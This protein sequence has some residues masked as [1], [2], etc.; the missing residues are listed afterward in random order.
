MHRFWFYSVHMLGW[1]VDEEACEEPVVT[2]DFDERFPEE[3]YSWLDELE[4]DE[5]C[6][7]G[8]VF[9][10]LTEVV[11]WTRVVEG[12]EESEDHLR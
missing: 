4:T 9:M 2:E 5:L 3:I 1:E 7:L 11:S 12:I 8:Q 6:E 10:F